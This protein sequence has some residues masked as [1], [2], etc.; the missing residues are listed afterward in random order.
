MPMSWEDSRETWDQW[1]IAHELLKMSKIQTRKLAIAT[2][3]TT[4]TE[5]K[6]K[7]R[8]QNQAANTSQ[9]QIKSTSFKNR[10]HLLKT[11]HP[12]AC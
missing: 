8:V 7:S 6:S 4:A 11:L 10:K 9:Q 5:A 2:Y 12:S 3:G 1:G